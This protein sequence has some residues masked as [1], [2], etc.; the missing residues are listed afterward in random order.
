MIGYGFK[1][2]DFVKKLLRR[3]AIEQDQDQ[4]DIRYKTSIKKGPI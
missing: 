1:D 4:I 3:K 2:E